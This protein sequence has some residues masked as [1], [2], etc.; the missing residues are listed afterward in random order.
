MLAKHFLC[1]LFMVGVAF[2]REASKFQSLP[3][4]TIICSGC[5]ACAWG[6]CSGCSGC[7]TVCIQ[8]KSNP[9]LRKPEQFPTG[10]PTGRQ[11]KPTSSPSV[12]SKHPDLPTPTLI[13]TLHPLDD[14]A[15]GDFIVPDNTADD[16][17]SPT[18]SPTRAR[19]IIYEEKAHGSKVFTAFSAG[20]VCLVAAL[21]YAAYKQKKKHAN[22]KRPD[23]NT[24][25]A[26]DSGNKA[27]T[28]LGEVTFAVAATI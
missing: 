10:R 9:T 2:G 25:V 19:S 26:N 27:K 21:I 16:N 13:P 24:A 6:G 18:L 7:R 5:T 23:L 12:A 20:A 4:C 8:P 17:S 15:Y 14:E 11:Q 28:T 3:D 1:L 22:V